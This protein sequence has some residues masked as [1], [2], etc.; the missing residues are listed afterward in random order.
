M[1]GVPGMK[2]PIRRKAMSGGDSSTT[3]PVICDLPVPDAPPGSAFSE[4]QQQRWEELFSSAVAWLWGEPEL[5]LVAAYVHLES[6]L[7]SGSGTAATIR[8]I[9]SLADSLGMS[10]ASRARMGVRIADGD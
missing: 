3:L 6:Q 9:K 10:P 2:Q 5:G 8:E 4:A 7:F 1:P